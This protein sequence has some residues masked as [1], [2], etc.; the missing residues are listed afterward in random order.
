[1]QYE[2]S[3]RENIGLILERLIY[4]M[5]QTGLGFGGHNIAY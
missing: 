1:M 5:H 3:M 2:N 4:Y